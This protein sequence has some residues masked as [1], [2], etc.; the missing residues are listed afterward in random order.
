MQFVKQNILNP[1]GKKCI[2]SICIIFKSYGDW[3][4]ITGN[5][6]VLKGPLKIV[7]AGC[8]WTGAVGFSHKFG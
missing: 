5:I 8:G 6:L 7:K 3:M 2:N 1:K 4:D